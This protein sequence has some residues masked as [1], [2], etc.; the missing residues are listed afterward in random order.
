M[1][2]N[3]GGEGTLISITNGKGARG[4]LA[5][6]PSQGSAARHGVC[7]RGVGGLTLELS[8]MVAAGRLEQR[9][10]TDQSGCD[11]TLCKLERLR[12]LTA[13]AQTAAA[14]PGIGYET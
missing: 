13:S 12:T 11:H 4:V 8:A 14:A 3:S 6:T 1:F 9:R 2:V 7:G 5:S 10:G